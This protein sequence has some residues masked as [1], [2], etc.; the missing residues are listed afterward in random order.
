MHCHSRGMI[1]GC[2]DMNHCG[3]GRK[4]TSRRLFS[5]QTILDVM[6]L[7]ARTLQNDSCQFF[8]K[9]LSIAP[10]LFDI[11]FGRKEGD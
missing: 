8:Q 5:L 3:K 10:T 4:Q 1:G 9:K 2:S 11:V 7:P 6:I